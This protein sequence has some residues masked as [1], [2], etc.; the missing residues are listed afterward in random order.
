MIKQALKISKP[1]DEYYTPEMAIKPLLKY[2]PTNIR[3]WECTDFGESNI[4]KVL[5]NH[6]YIENTVSS[7]WCSINV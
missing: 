5:R 3:I 4:T 2:L 6:G 1:N 7:Y